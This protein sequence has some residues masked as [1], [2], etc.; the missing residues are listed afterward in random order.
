MRTAFPYQ[1]IIIIKNIFTEII[2]FDF[3]WFHSI[4]NTLI[5]DA[6]LEH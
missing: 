1:K 2:L 5:P 4:T 3:A 6:T